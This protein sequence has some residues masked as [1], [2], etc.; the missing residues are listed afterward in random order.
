M[1]DSSAVPLLRHQHEPF[2]PKWTNTPLSRPSLGLCFSF[3]NWKNMEDNLEMFINPLIT[4]KKK[5]PFRNISG[6]N[7]LQNCRILLPVYLSLFRL[8]VQI[9]LFWH[10]HVVSRLIFRKWSREKTHFNFCKDLEPL[11]LKMWN[12]QCPVRVSCMCPEQ[13]TLTSMN[14]MFSLHVP[15]RV[16]L[17]KCCLME[18]APGG[19]QMGLELPS[20]LLKIGGLP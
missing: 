16:T 11:S 19:L 5:N 8:P 20:Q 15:C 1:I 14:C 18:A 4:D 12:S 2:S 10:N 9:C 17:R 13:P 7:N 6:D 3:S